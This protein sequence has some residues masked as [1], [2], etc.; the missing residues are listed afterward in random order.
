[1][2]E[3]DCYPGKRVGRLTLIS[4][5]RVT[6]KHYGNRWQW[7]CKCDCGNTREVLT[8]QLGEYSSRRGIQDCGNHST[9][10]RSK[11]LKKAKPP[12]PDNKVSDSNN[13]SKWRH[14]YSKWGDMIRRCYS[15]QL[16]NYPNYG[17]RGI[18]VCDEWRNS[19]ETFKKWAIEQ[20][21]DPNNNN[22]NEQTLDRIDVNGN[23]EPSN[24][25]LTNIKVQSNNKT[26]NVY[27]TIHG[28]THTLMEWSDLTGIVFPTLNTRYHNGDRG[29]AL[30]REVD[31]RYD[32]TIKKMLSIDGKN[33]SYRELSEQTGIG[34]LELIKMNKDGRIEE[35]LSARV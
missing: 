19:Y 5:K 30:I 31:Q 10:N 18:R 24:C 20:G 7:L 13:R 21:Y 8:F 35:E 3:A 28:K 27:V 23:Y 14:L 29:E 34:I 15:P 1:M 33:Y 6:T 12:L 17:G 16:A 9:E 2:K 22:R 4:R 26:D 32:W 11:A 25:R